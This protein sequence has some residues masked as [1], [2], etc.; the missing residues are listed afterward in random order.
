MGTP[1]DSARQSLPLSL[2]YTSL[3]TGDLNAIRKQKCFIC[4]PCYGRAC[5]WAMLGELKPKGP[6]GHRTLSSP[7]DVPVSSLVDPRPLS[8]LEMELLEL[9]LVMVSRVAKG[10][11]PS[12][13]LSVADRCTW[14]D[15]KSFRSSRSF[16]L[17]NLW[18]PQVYGPTSKV[19]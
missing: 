4:S 6:K 13:S 10:V 8:L 16:I 3:C 12:C 2:L 18:T 7:L 9:E 15:V 14:C 19:Q 17:S 11:A 1:L 5:R